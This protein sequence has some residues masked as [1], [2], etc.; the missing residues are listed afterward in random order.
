MS[1]I[2]T[3]ATMI[4]L[5]GDL[6]LDH[7]NIIKYCNRPFSS[8]EEMNETLVKRWNE[9][10]TVEDTVYYLGD[11]AYGRGSRDGSWWW[12]K[13]NGN[14]I[15]IKGNHDRKESIRGITPVHKWHIA[16]LG[17]VRFLLIHSPDYD[18]PEWDGWMIHGHHHNNFPELYPLV[19]KEKKTINVSAE[20]LDYYPL[21]LNELL[22]LL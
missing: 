20:M 9:T 2:L 14:K 15:L 18:K 5:I 12:Q 7:T 22:N 3:P 1:S 19:N 13:L 16:E 11:I 17:G 10:V 8:V 6:H 4:Y 21:S